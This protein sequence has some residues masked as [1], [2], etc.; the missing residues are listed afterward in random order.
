MKQNKKIL[1]LLL[2]LFSLLTFAY[3]TQATITNAVTASQL[4]AYYSD[5]DL[6]KTEEAFIL[7]LTDVTN[8]SN[9]KRYPY[10]SS[11]TDTW[12]ILRE[13]DEDPNNSN[14]I[15]CLYSGLSIPKND[16]DG[17]ASSG[18]VYV[19]NRE[20]LWAKSHGF[21]DESGVYASAYTD[22]HHLHASE[23]NINAVRGNSDFDNIDGNT[24]Y[25]SYSNYYEEYGYGTG[26]YYTSTVFEPR[27]EVKGDVARS[28]LYMMVKYND[29]QL[30]LTLIENIPTK[31]DSNTNVGYLG[32]LSTII[33]WHY[34]D[35]VDDFERNR[36][37]VVYSYQNNRNPFID[38]PEYVDK[39]WPNDYEDNNDDPV[40][41]P[42]TPELSGE[43]TYTF[44]GKNWSTNENAWNSNKD[45][46]GFN[47]SNNA[48]GV[49]ITQ[50]FSGAGCT[51]KNT[52]QSVNKII[53]TYC[54]NAANGAGS[55]TIGIGSNPN[56]VKNVTNSGGTTSRQLIY[57]YSPSQSGAITMTI[58]TTTNSIYIYSIEI[59]SDSGVIEAIQ[60]DLDAI[61]SYM[62]MGY[63]Y[64][65]N[66]SSNTTKNDIITANSLNATSTSY[67]EF[68]N[69]TF[70]S[71]AVYAG[72]NA[73][74]GNGAIQL[75]TNN[76][77]SGIVSTASGG[78]V[79]KI[80]IV[81]DSATAI[82]RTVDIY[83]SNE[84][85]ASASDLYNVSNQGT[86]LG[87]I[88]YGS[89]TVL[90][91]NGDY[92]YIGLKSNSGALYLSSINVE[93]GSSA[94]SFTDVDFRIRCGVDKSLSTLVIDLD[95]ATYGIEVSDGTNTKQYLS[96]STF[97]QTE[98]DEN[99]KSF[100]II[101]L[102][103]ALTNQERLDQAFTVK[104][105][106]K[107]NG[108]TYYSSNTKTYSICSL[109]QTYID[110]NDANINNQISG[111][112]GILENLGKVFN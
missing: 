18:A 45:G 30:N 14:N 82:G 44:T 28:L 59:Y 92:S 27:D 47:I 83:G 76:N 55:V 13:A 56:T 48:L 26:N 93:W 111:L 24:A 100:V 39:A 99:G 34:L 54:T 108:I 64:T 74:N 80:T 51:S 61:N 50:G 7:E 87:S 104:A 91:V 29:S 38:H 105:F 10:S 41:D 103:D 11:S 58:T 94:A 31:S 86:K 106:I 96:S 109:L 71:S 8:P 32:K 98:I 85:Y 49:Q 46:S 19:W 77:N 66:S 23:K 69:V 22:C 53:V 112:V 95:G 62:S 72:C 2:F 57:D 17:S 5:V 81:W 1:L 90:E 73:K 63:R 16:Q 21:P 102:G 43:Y 75:R 25:N 78:K 12:D 3:T 37:D 88:V 107:Y 20:H 35:P 79:G 97:F 6:T 110:M 68:A 33:E 15:I 4:E 42:S 36:N 70:S 52:Y 101:D 65:Y 9:Y 40:I 60:T 67:T 89:S 84:A